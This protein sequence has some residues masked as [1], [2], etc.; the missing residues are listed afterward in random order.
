[1]SKVSGVG[2]FVGRSERLDFVFDL[3]AGLDV[4]EVSPELRDWIG[5]TAHVAFD[6]DVG[7]DFR[8]H[9]PM[10]VW[11]GPGQ[12]LET[13]RPSGWEMDFTLTRMDAA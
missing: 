13:L 4:G 2:S 9:I 6:G 11:A 10:L 12:P 1:M 5:A 7:D 8:L 3:W